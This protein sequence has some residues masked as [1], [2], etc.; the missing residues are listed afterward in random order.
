M[1]GAKHQNPYPVLLATV[2][3][4]GCLLISWTWASSRTCPALASVLTAA[5]PL[6][7]SFLLW[8]SQLHMA[9]VTVCSSH[10]LQ[11]ISVHRSQ[12]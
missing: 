4:V 5:R 3:A 1:P 11:P 8:L 10:H 9:S 7:G 6:A 12:L 2:D